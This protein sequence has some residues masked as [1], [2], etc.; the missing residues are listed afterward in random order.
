MLVMLGIFPNVNSLP[1]QNSQSS[2]IKTSQI[3][4]YPGLTGDLCSWV[5]PGENQEAIE[6]YHLEKERETMCSSFGGLLKYPGE[7][8]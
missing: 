2:Q 3:Q 8:S 5:A 1:T 4:K 7:W 6:G